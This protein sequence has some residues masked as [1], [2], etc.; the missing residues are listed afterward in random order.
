MVDKSRLANTKGELGPI[1]DKCGTLLT[2]GESCTVE[3]QYVCYPCYL[4]LTGAEPAADTNPNPGL[5]M[6]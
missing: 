3:Q 6:N 4:E 5:R 1:C 2:F